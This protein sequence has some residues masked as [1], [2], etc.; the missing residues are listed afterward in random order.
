VL[1]FLYLQ[2]SLQFTFG[3]ISTM[4]N[5]TIKH[6]IVEKN[7]SPSRFADEIGVQRSSISH[8]LSGRNKPSLDIVQKI[9]RRFPELGTD[10]LVEEPNLPVPSAPSKNNA[11]ESERRDHFNGSGGIGPDEEEPEETA[12]YH[13]AGERQ[14]T[15][16]LV[17]YS[18]GTFSE[19][20]P[21]GK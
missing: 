19:F 1:T 14:I 4:L 9:I 7:L 8:I 16:V 12:G 20:S 6:I 17:F 11:I 10:W 18:D 3:Y 15:K 2:F 21:A 13:R 5:D